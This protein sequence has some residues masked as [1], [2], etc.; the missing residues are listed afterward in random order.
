M[1]TEEA[2]QILGEEA[3]G[4]TDEQL[5]QVLSSFDYLADKLLE[6]YEIKVFGKPL[7]VLLD[8]GHQRV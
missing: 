8:N 7:E 2:R 3:N 6:E 5:T 1:S 4:L